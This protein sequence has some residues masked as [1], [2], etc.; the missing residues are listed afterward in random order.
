MEQD[1]LTIN[2]YLWLG[3]SGLIVILV[4]AFKTGITSFIADKTKKFLERVIHREFDGKKIGEEVD[5]VY[6]RLIEI[7]TISL[8]NRVSINRFHNGTV[9][10]PS[11]PAWKISRVYEICSDG[12]SYEAQKFQNVMAMLIWDS[13]KAIFESKFPNYIEKIVSKTNHYTIFKYD[14]EKMPESFSK[15]TMRRH[16]IKVYIQIPLINKDK[17]FGYL[18]IDYLSKKDIELDIERIYPKITEISYFLSKE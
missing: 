16:G 10:L 14:V 2:H 8:S 17:V 3:I 7:K 15:V 5:F 12:I 6:E 11:Q 13:I 4:T 18:Q 1:L 9:F